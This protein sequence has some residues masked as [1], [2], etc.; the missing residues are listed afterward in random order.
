MANLI[1][2]AAVAAFA[3]AAFG[4]CAHSTGASPNAGGG[5]SAAITGSVA[6]RERVALPPDAVAEVSLIDAT[7]QDVAATTVATTMVRSEGKQVPIPFTLRYDASRIDKSH[8]YTV[9][10]VIKSGAQLL[11]TTDIVRAVITQ[12]NPTHVDLMLTRVDPG[13]ASGGGGAGARGELAG[14]SWVLTDLGN[15]RALD[16]PPTTLDFATKGKASGSG[17]CNRYFATVEISGTSIRFGAVGATRMTCAT[18]VSLQE[19]R[20]F[21]ALESS[22]RFDVDGN[23]LSIYG[24][25]TRP[26][27]F[28]RAAP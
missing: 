5:E 15:A 9:R 7:A 27:R 26:L 20:Y 14:S 16:D 25:G 11:W 17:S 18:P 4:A 21:E 28:T 3:F 8:L 24:S 1:P 2:R 13:A 22:S 19:V 10:A 23:T 6:Y 12:G